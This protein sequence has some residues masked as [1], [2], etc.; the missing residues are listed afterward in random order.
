MRRIECKRPS[1]LPRGI[2]FR[3]GRLRSGLREPVVNAKT[4]ATLA[5]LWS[6]FEPAI[7]AYLTSDDDVALWR[8]VI[9]AVV[10]DANRLCSLYRGRAQVFVQVGC[11]S[12]WLAPH[13]A[14]WITED[15]EFVWPSGYLSKG[16][17]FGGLPELDWQAS[18]ARNAGDGVWLPVERMRARR[19]FLLRVAVPAR[20]ARHQRASVHAMWSPGPPPASKQ[21]R[22]FYGFRK[23]S[24]GWTFKVYR[25]HARLH[26]LQTP[27]THDTV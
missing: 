27:T 23:S 7:A 19:L 1:D 21:D 17:F 24:Q 10:G 15:G 13:K 12:H 18:W 4:Q 20:T 22:M 14:H 25:G 11:C 2:L 5:G 8:S 9:E 6:Q 26:Q 3:D 16:N